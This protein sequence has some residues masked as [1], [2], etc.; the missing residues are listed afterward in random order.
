[1]P[2]TL[3][4]GVGDLAA[5]VPKGNSSSLGAGNLRPGTGCSEGKSA[6][7]LLYR[8]SRERFAGQITDGP[9]TCLPEPAE[10]NKLP[11]LCTQALR[12]GRSPRAAQLPQAQRSHL[13]EGSLPIRPSLSR[14]SSYSE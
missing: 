2:T 6:S 1:M 10:I 11:S 12:T 3:L 14:S 7:G 13:S 4:P 9:A 8:V 5:R